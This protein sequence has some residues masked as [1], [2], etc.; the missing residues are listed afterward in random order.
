MFSLHALTFC[1]ILQDGQ[2]TNNYVSG[3]ISALHFEQFKYQLIESI[4]KISPFSIMISSDGISLL[5]TLTEIGSVS[6]I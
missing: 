6:V 3:S 4:L 5:L 2:S 1:L